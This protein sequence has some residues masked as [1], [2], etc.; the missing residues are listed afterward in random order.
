M[1]TTSVCGAHAFAGSKQEE[2]ERGR[3]KESSG[4]PMTMGYLVEWSFLTP[5]N[6]KVQELIG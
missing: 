1:A 2:V 3:K 4:G 6:M 5:R